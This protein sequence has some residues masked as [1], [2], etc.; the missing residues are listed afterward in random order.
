MTV[1]I[2]IVGDSGDE[3]VI[4]CDSQASGEESEYHG[5][6]KLFLGDDF[7]IGCAGSMAV[8]HRLFETL[9]SQNVTAD[10]LCD[11][12]ERFVVEDLTEAARHQFEVIALAANNSGIRVL[13]PSLF[14]AFGPPESFSCIGSGQTFVY[15]ELS[16][17]QKHRIERDTTTL[18]HLLLAVDNYAEA[19]NESLTVDDWHLVGILFGGRAYLT[20]H[21]EIRPSF[22]SSQVRKDWSKN[23]QFYEEIRSLVEQIRSEISTSYAGFSA[24]Q[25]GTLDQQSFP[26]FEAS[27]NAVRNNLSILQTKLIEF[28]KWFDSVR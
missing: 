12:V 2:G 11:T 27:S 26:L 5:V 8:I 28:T 7:L 14:N 19:A 1:H 9:E 16:Y 4:F 13:T 18:A 20:G 3:G 17:E 21:P 24:V 10:Q 25:N 23:S 22:V 15:R 6:Q